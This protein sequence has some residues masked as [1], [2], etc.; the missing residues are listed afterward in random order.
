MFL[1]AVDSETNH[2]Q[3]AA[4]GLIDINDVHSVQ[5]KSSGPKF[6]SP[7]LEVT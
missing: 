4:E 1:L 3:R 5:Q 6:L 2:G 7:E